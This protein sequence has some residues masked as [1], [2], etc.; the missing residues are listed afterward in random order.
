MDEAKGLLGLVSQTEALVWVLGSRAET[1]AT[2][3]GLGA[4]SSSCPDEISGSW[5][6]REW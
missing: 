2:F 3:W 6:Q 1:S 4:E 5:L